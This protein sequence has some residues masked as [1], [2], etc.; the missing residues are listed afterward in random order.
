MFAAFGQVPLEFA[1][2][3]SVPSRTDTHHRRSGDST[4][5]LG[6][7]TRRARGAQLQVVRSVTAFIGEVAYDGAPPRPMAL[8]DDLAARQCD[9]DPTRALPTWRQVAERSVAVREALRPEDVLARA[10]CV[11][12]L[13]RS[14][15]TTCPSVSACTRILKMTIA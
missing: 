9:C 10:L 15:R 1:S 3:R 2:P 14:Q 13:A 6:Q 8:I 5:R 11:A 12:D 7:R 4:W